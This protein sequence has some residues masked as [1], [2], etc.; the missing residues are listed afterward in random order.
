MSAT[1]PSKAFK[2]RLWIF[3]V[4]AV[5]L[6]LWDAARPGVSIYYSLEGREE[7]SYIWNVQDRISKG[8]MSPGGGSFDSGFMF[9]NEDFFMEFSWWSLKTGRNHCISI[10]PKWRHTKVYLDPDGE[11]DMSKKG[12]TNV[13]RLKECQWDRAK[14]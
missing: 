14:P 9:P 1:N 10:M 13:D 5:A 11:I 4:P 7:F 8:K 3:I 2:R 6:C 12:G